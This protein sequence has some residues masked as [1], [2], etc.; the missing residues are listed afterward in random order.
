MPY[1]EKTQLNFCRTIAVNLSFLPH[2]NDVLRKLTCIL[3]LLVLPI[4]AAPESLRISTKVR[5]ELTKITAYQEATK[6]M[7]DQ[8]PEVAV[9]KF[10]AVLNTPKL[11]TEAKAA[12]NLMLVESL[13]RASSSVGG[14]EKQALDALTI[15]KDKSLATFPV[16]TIWQAEALA[17][18]GRYQEAEQA[19]SKLPESYPLLDEA[20]LA[21]SRILIALNKKPEALTLLKL[22]SQSKNAVIR[23]TA[24]LLAAE[25][26]IDSGQTEP[27]QK[28]LENADTENAAAAKLKEYLSARLALSENKTADAVN[29]F[30]SLITAPDHLNERIYHACILG[31]ADAHAANGNKES[32]ITT[33]EQFIDDHAHSYA[34]QAAFSRLV[35]LL[36]KELPNDLPSLEKLRLWSHEKPLPAEHGI[37]N[38]SDDASG[39]VANQ[40]ASAENYDLMALAL[41]YRAK[42]LIRTENPQNIQR[43][44][45]LLTRLRTIYT[46]S[47]Q[48]PSELYLELF[49]ASLLDTAYIHLLQNQPDQATF[50]LSVMEKIAFSPKLKDQA[51]VLRGEILAREDD[52]E[53][54]MRAFSFARQ[55]ASEQIAD[56]ANINAGIMALKASN[57]VAFDEILKTTHDADIKA[58]LTL[59]RAL[60]KCHQS[61]IQGRN[62]LEAFIMAHPDHPRENE[63]RLALAAACV[64]TTPP[65]IPLAKAQLDIIAPRMT[66]DL[67]QAKITRIRIRAE[68]LLED[69]LAAAK[70]AEQFLSKFSTSP[71]TRVIMLQRGEAY[72]HNEDYNK[73]RL[74]FQDFINKYPDDKLTPYA[75]FYAA[76]AARLSGTAQSREECITMFQTIIDSKHAL[77]SEA[78]I[79]Q[80]RVLIDLRRYEEAEKVLK[81]LMDNKKSTPEEKLGAGVL[82]ADCL[83]RQG[84]TD[85]DKNKQAIDIY[86]KLLEQKDISLAW[87]HRLHYLRGQAY[88]NMKETSKAFKSYYD[89]IIQGKAPNTPQEKQEEWFWFYRCGFKA[90]TMLEN[91]ERWETSVK[92]AKRIASFN[93]PRAEE[94]DKRAKD[95]AKKHMIWPEETINK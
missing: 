65:D 13:V 42:L 21:R 56:T 10:R 78:R 40:I 6:A 22:L 1:L 28:L 74:I 30:Q 50:T 81:P 36:P 24:L 47:S 62:D 92:V 26:Q 14:E 63:A 15:L 29:R 72:Y 61:D 12:V 35:A 8:L 64:N 60:W 18:L 37:L 91:T 87:S 46:Q 5:K 77:S 73:A 48:S 82:M 23:N 16:A 80:G 2:N 88:E 39:A 53:N 7:A 67:E 55:S 79:Q 19:L 89:V 75:R 69:W 3:C 54:A 27:A 95:L 76:M 49:S 86:N 17:T 57:M 25:I 38:P 9:D 43:A 59:E 20:K 33:L 32:A 93:G 66:T 52:Y 11:S 68:Q 70:A 34:L 51:S 58:S 94:A 45:A 71:E 44:E 85:P 90:L 83:Q 84:I 4:S 41:Y 31:L